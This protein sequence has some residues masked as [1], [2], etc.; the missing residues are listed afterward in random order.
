MTAIGGSRLLTAP[1]ASLQ[2]EIDF[3]VISSDL[4]NTGSHWTPNNIVYTGG[5][6]DPSIAQAALSH[7]LSLSKRPSGVVAANNFIAMGFIRAVR[8]RGMDIP[9]HFALACFDKIEPGRPDQ[10]NRYDGDSTRI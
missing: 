7:F 3:S 10:T 5:T 2:R 4:N 1:R 9:S 8:E 6:F